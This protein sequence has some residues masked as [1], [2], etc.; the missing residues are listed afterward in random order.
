MF[1][2]F[3]CTLLVCLRDC[4][5]RRHDD[6]L[7]RILYILELYIPSFPFRQHPIAWSLKIHCIGRRCRLGGVT[8]VLFTHVSDVVNRALPSP[9]SIFRDSPIASQVHHTP[10][11]I[12]E[13]TPHS[14]MIRPLVIHAL[15]AR[16]C[17]FASYLHCDHHQMP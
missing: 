10:R 15:Q 12:T 5:G 17:L 4:G 14:K 6:V 16:L 1:V 13:W 2:V 7:G 3:V 9:H 8:H 11:Q